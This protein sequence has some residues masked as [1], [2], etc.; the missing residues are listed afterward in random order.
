MRVARN[1]GF[2]DVEIIR[3]LLG[4][5]KST[6]KSIGSLVWPSNKVH[7]LPGHTLRCHQL[8]LQAPLLLV[9]QDEHSLSQAFLLADGVERA[10]GPL[11]VA[12]PK[13][14]LT[15]SRCSRNDRA[16]LGGGVEI[17]SAPDG[18]VCPLAS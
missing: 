11:H 7:N 4:N 2:N 5:M 14:E 17:R 6:E 16:V 18:S 8:P 1:E 3:G 10:K 9:L 12:M 13:K 15:C